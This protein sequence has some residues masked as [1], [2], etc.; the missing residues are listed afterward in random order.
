MG[1][2]LE[3]KVGAEPRSPHRGSAAECAARGAGR[4]LHSAAVP[5]RPPGATIALRGGAPTA[6]AAPRRPGAAPR[7][8]PRPRTRAAA[9]ARAAAGVGAGASSAPRFPAAVGLARSLLLGGG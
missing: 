5:P 2:V 3:V 4:K 1:T 6:P 9:A 8:V 7:S